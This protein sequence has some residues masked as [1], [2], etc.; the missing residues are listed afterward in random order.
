MGPQQ[1][2][3]PFILL[4][5]PASHCRY[6]LPRRARARLPS[7]AITLGCPSRQRFDTHRLLE[8]SWFK[9]QFQYEVHRALD[10]D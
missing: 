1:H 2:R 4:I 3:H 10:L 5:L 7:N 8:R 6:P 9:V